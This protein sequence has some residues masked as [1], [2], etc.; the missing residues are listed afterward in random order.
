VPLGEHG[1]CIGNLDTTLVREAPRIGPHVPAMRP[2]LAATLGI[3]VGLVSV[4]AKT[5]DGL[6]FAGRGEGMACHAIALIER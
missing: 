1:C 2:H 4:K 6:G 3:P 5:I